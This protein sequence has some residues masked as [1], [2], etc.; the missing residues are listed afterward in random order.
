MAN[1]NKK[2]KA[3]LLE[4]IAQQEKNLE[5]MSLENKTLSDE[6]NQFH[7][8]FV[9]LDEE[10]KNL[11]SRLSEFTDKVNIKEQKLKNANKVN[12]SMFIGLVLTLIA[13]LLTLIRL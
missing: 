7:K 11:T 12:N 10:N 8:M 13:W 5:Q 9:D 1:L 2:T 4:I 6:R 3:E